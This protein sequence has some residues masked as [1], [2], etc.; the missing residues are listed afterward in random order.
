MKAQ[1]SMETILITIIIFIV[2]AMMLSLTI[3]KQLDSNNIK[4]ALQKTN[5]CD[6]FAN[7]V[8][9]VFILG[10]GTKSTIRLDYNINVS[11][12]TAVID[13]VIC[14]ICCNLTKNSSLIYT[15]QAG[16]NQLENK[17]GNL[18]IG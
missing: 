8:K 6:A 12:K 3:S 7:E 17:N 1:T 16:N 18:V 11:G 2:F 15:L 14:K 4:T 10:N 9:S 5:A 13:S